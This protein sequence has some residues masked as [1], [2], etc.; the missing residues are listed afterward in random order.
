MKNYLN[1]LTDCKFQARNIIGLLI[2]F[3]I[4]MGGQLCNVIDPV[5]GAK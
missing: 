4:Y 2:R 1:S 3:S 5:T